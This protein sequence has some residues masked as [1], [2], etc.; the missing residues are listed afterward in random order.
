LTYA[1]ALGVLGVLQ[2]A[3]GAELRLAGIPLVWSGLAWSVVALGYAGLGPR[4]FGKRR[5]G[6]IPA[7]R[8]VPLFPFIALTWTVW[9]V[10]GSGPCG[11]EIVPGLWLGRRP[12]R[13]ELPADVGA[14]LD[15]TSEFPR[16]ADAVEPRT[17]LCEPLLDATAPPMETLRRLVAW[18]ESSP[19][20]VYVHCAQGNGRSA[21]VVAAVL[22]A[23]GLASDANGAVALI[24]AVRRSVRPNA[25]QCAVL[26]EFA[27]TVAV[28]HAR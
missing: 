1:F 24:R 25:K 12:A 7:G 9:R 28:R 20:P 6:S 16:P 5:D 8:C 10:R 3:L 2:I 26:E 19:Q 13:G 23:R 11:H 4:V 22:L 14:I 17:Y 27:R 21:T 15:L 18:I